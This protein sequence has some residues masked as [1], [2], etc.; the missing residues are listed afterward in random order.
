MES[1]HPLLDILHRLPSLTL[2]PSAINRGPTGPLL[3]SAS[4]LVTRSRVSAALQSLR[5]GSA[6]LDL[7][8]DQ[9]SA[10]LLTPS[11]DRVTPGYYL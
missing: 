3:S 11:L 2:C 5:D 8:P 1:S 7:N 10:P 4:C 9:R 6:A